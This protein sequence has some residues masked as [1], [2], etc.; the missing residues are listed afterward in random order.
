[1]EAW[2]EVNLVSV[3]VQDEDVLELVDAIVHDQLAGGDHDLVLL[4]GAGT[5]SPNSLARAGAPR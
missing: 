4:L 3:R 2:T 1:M 5:A